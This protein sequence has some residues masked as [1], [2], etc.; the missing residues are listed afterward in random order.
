MTYIDGFVLAVPTAHKE[1]YRKHAESSLPLFKRHG[2]IHMMETWGTDVPDGKL[3]SFPMAVK[4]QPDETVV[5]SWV[6]WPDKE[7]RDKAWEAMP[8]DPEMNQS[9][10]MPFDGKRMIYGGFSPLLEADL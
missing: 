8:N 1:A 6:V 3:T 7:T 5:F 4:L 9:M 2:A 10:E